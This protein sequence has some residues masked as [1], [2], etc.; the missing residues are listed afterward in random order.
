MN[1]T[2]AIEILDRMIFEEVP[3]DVGLSQHIDTCPSCSQAYTDALKAREVMKLVRRSEP[4]LRDPD[5]L[6]GNIMAAIPDGQVKT[7]VV[8]LL[9]SRLLAAAS[10]A[11][12]LVF[13]Y[14]QYGVVKKIS[15]LEKQFAEIKSDSRYSDLLQLASTININET[16]IS[17]SEIE[18]LLS[19]EKGRSSLC[20]SCIKKRLDQRTIK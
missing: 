11:I 15:T 7:F 16:G 13:G 18:R 5:G 14:E 8:P 1:C 17:L 4:V 3:A 10:I 19:T 2:D 6:T 9:L 12:I 20:I